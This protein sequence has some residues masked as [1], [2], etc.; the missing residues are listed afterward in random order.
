MG[1][2]LLINLAIYHLFYKE[3]KLTTFDAG[4]AAALGFAPALMHYALDVAGLVTVVGAFRYRRLD[5]GGGADRCTPPP[6]PTC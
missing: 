2:I 3:L 1:G 4:L 5:P 6:P